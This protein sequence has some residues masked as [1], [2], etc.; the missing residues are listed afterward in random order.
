[1]RRSCKLSLT[2]LCLLSSCSAG[3][4]GDGGPCGEWWLHLQRVQ[5]C[6]DAGVAEHVAE[7]KVQPLEVAEDRV[8]FTF[9]NQEWDVNVTPSGSFSGWH[10]NPGVTAI[11]GG[12][13]D[14]DR[15]AA[16]LVFEP[17]DKDCK[18]AYRI[19]GQ[20]I[21]DYPSRVAKKA[22]GLPLDAGEMGVSQ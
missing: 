13:F 18:N 20:K 17:F 21:L 4:L 11:F 22:A 14:G 16:D 2:L 5:S 8:R 3:Q 1:M 15:L 6:P 10:D 12:R 19:A 9:G 7:A